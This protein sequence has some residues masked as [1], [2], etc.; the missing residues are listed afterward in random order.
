[1]S[2]RARTA[3]ATTSRI[4]LSP[5][6]DVTGTNTRAKTAQDPLTGDRV[7]LFHPRRDTW[8]DHFQW[9]DDFAYIIGITPIGRATVA[10]LHLNLSGVVNLPQVTS[11]TWTAPAIWSQDNVG[12][13]TRRHIGQ[14][15][16]DVHELDVGR[17]FDPVSQSPATHAA[18][19]RRKTTSDTMGGRQADAVPIVSL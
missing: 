16:F 6:W 4:W 19:L 17:G 3:A 9:S 7:R 12:L 15:V 5:A 1:M 13:L 11:S 10:C 18:S 2:S 8:S 14:A